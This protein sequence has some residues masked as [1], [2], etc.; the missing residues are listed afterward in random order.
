M[1]PPPAMMETV[2]ETRYVALVDVFEPSGAAAQEMVG[3]HETPEAALAAAEAEVRQREERGE[4][5]PFM[6]RAVTLL[7]WNQEKGVENP[8]LAIGLI[9]N[10][11]Q[12]RCGRCDYLLLQRPAH[13]SEHSTLIAG[14]GVPAF[15]EAIAR[16]LGRFTCP[17]CGYSWKDAS[18]L[19]PRAW[20]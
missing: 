11:L 10:E 16:E 6:A 7:E 14:T 19:I 1:N 8:G 9:G 3:I 4:P 13:P 18:E 12:V 2:T 5:G 17:N 15:L 20:D